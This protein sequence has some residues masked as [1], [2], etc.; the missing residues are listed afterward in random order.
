M[1]YKQ[2]QKMW[3]RKT[4]ARVRRMKA[5]KAKGDHTYAEWKMMVR[6]FDNHCVRC[7]KRDFVQCDHIVPVSEGGSNGMGNLQ[8]LCALCNTMKG[9]WDI[10]DYRPGF[11]EKAGLT[12]PKEWVLA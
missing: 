4:V 10:V 3:R 9:F 2:K 5:A 7:G 12:L 6:F 1:N 11:C 8:P